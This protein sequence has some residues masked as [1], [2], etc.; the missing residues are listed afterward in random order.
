MQ[1]WHAAGDRGGNWGSAI[2]HYPASLVLI[3]YCFA[4]MWFVGGLSFF[5]AWLV[6]RNVTTYEHFRHRYS[7]T[8]NPYSVGI[9]G[10][11]AEVMCT[12]TPPRWTP[13]WD[14][15]RAE[16]SAGLDENGLANGN[17]NGIHGD[18][19]INGSIIGYESADDGS[20]RGPRMSVNASNN[21]EEASH[22]NQL[23]K[24]G[25]NYSGS[26][27]PSIGDESYGRPSVGGG[28]YEGEGGDLYEAS[29]PSSPRPNSRASGA[30]F[31]VEA[32][33][34]G[35]GGGARDDRLRIRKEIESV[36]TDDHGHIFGYERFAASVE[37]PDAY[38]VPLPVFGKADAR[39]SV[40]SFSST[41]HTSSY[42]NQ[43]YKEIGNMRA[44]SAVS[45]DPLDLLHSPRV[46]SG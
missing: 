30:A 11:I 16:D 3:I 26:L 35:S 22:Y 7:N 6:A 42:T 38:S 44:V 20:F 13:L 31:E 46:N 9:F 33:A 24:N 37:S 43:N 18:I 8:G 27:P 32:Y 14:K 21:Y 1:L 40:T 34:T 2:G 17:G 15:Q 39:D 25:R 10:N 23:R 41:S 19:S 28:S 5:H 4:M 36:N 29:L 45:F 12:K